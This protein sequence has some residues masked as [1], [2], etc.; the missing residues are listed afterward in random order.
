MQNRVIGDLKTPCGKRDVLATFDNRLRGTS[1]LNRLSF[2][3]CA[4]AFL[5][6]SPFFAARKEW[7]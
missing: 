5:G 3:H 1:V 2:N 6:F 4:V 7:A